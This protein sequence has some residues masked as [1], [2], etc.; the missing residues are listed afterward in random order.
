MIVW[1]VLPLLGAM[2]GWW[3]NRLAL[4]M[5]FRPYR[6]ISILGWRWQGVIPRRR[7][8]LA[9][10]LARALQEHLLTPEDQRALLEAVEIVTG[11]SDYEYT[12]VVKGALK[13]GQKLV[14]GLET[15]N[16]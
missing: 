16:R 2:I 10:A 4:W 3:T 15:S 12:E 1:I 14:S 11:L 7:E 6:A 13:K 5:L 9:D 8:Q